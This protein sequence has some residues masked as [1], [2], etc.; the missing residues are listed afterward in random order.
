[1]SR[2]RVKVELD[3]EEF[4]LGLCEAGRNGKSWDGK[5]REGN[6]GNKVWRDGITL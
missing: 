4:G 5:G 3:R 2:E 1:M 6:V